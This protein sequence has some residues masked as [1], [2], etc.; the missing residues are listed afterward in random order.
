MTN[1]TAKEIT[2]ALMARQPLNIQ[3]LDSSYF[4]GKKVGV[5]IVD[6]VDGFCEPG[7][8]PLSPPVEDPMIEAMIQNTDT[9]ARAAFRKGYPILVLQEAHTEDHPEPPYPP[10]CI[11]GSGHELLVRE[12]QW[13]YECPLATVVPKGCIDGVIGAID[14][15]GDNA[16]FE[17]IEEHEIEVMIMV[18]IC[19]D[20]CN[21]QFGQSILSARNR[22]LAPPLK[23]LVVYTA[24]CS[25]YNLPIEIAVTLPPEAKPKNG[26]LEHLAHDQEICHYIGLYLLQGS[27]A[28][29]A[30]S[31]ESVKKFERGE[32][33]DD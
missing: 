24:G 5:V 18:G 10:H 32:E 21:S 15:W 14:E 4:T 3:K 31:V 2:A 22:D 11:V 13:L 23:D 7:C 1:L 12:L 16:V 19:T 27:G 28:I 26:M 20:I 30:K 33:A 6:I 17:W 25:T 29:L 8:G 9:L